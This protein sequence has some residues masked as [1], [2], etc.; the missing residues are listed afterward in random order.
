[1]SRPIISKYVSKPDGEGWRALPQDHGPSV[2]LR[3][4]RLAGDSPTERLRTATPVRPRVSP[5]RGSVMSRGRRRRLP[6]GGHEG[7]GHLSRRDSVRSEGGC[8]QLAPPG[9]CP[10]S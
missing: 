6:R 4:D 3:G 2:Q 8:L 5:T 7:E 10:L 9:C 1:M